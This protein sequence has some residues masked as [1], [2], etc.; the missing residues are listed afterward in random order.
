[1][2]YIGKQLGFTNLAGDELFLDADSDTSITASTDDQ[3]DIKIGGADDF[4]F[5]ANSFEVQGSSNIDMNGQELILDADG[6]TSITAD[7]D[8]TIDIKVAGSDLYHFTSTHLD[9]NG[10]ELILDAD[11]DTSIT[12]DTDD[13]IDVKLAGTDRI[14]LHGTGKLSVADNTT[15]FS[16]S[17]VIEGRGT[18]ATG[19]A[20]Q[21]QNDE[22]SAYGQVFIAGSGYNAYG[23][24]GSDMW[25]YSPNNV[26][27]GSHAA[28]LVKLVSN[29]GIRLQV[30]T[31]GS[32]TIGG[33]LSKGSGSFRID[34][35]LESK[36]DTHYLVHSFIE[37]PQADLIYRGKATLSSG[38]ASVNIDTTNGMT[39][40]TFVALCRDITCYTNNETGWT[41]VKGSVSGNILTIT[42][43]DNS[44]TD[45]ISWM[46]VGE[47]QDDHMK[48]NN[49]GWTDSDGKIIIEPL[50][51][52]VAT[53]EGHDAATSGNSPAPGTF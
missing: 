36:K 22:N 14:R 48:D 4:A 41:P 29:N 42:A 8:D 18:S 1:M 2:P 7:T 43:Q 39:D 19:I 34:H 10:K 38:T 35:P 16:T 5:K 53:K 44:C 45:T 12:A 31:D 15:A 26:T 3:I 30:N 24:T 13:Q 37:G 27:V 11:A 25:L 9:I 17:H 33:A 51:S 28:K 50:K 6:D 52:D 20:L 46:V 49:T 23:A 47:R 32:V 21:M 40:G